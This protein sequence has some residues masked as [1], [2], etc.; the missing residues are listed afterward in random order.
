MVGCKQLTGIDLLLMQASSGIV[1]YCVPHICSFLSGSYVYS[2]IL[3]VSLFMSVIYLA[4]NNFLHCISTL[5]N[6]YDSVVKPVSLMTSVVI[7]TF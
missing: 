4:W 1:N 6:G 5:I 7:Y 2:L 3:K